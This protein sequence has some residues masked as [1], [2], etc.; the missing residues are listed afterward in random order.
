VKAHCVPCNSSGVIQGIG[1]RDVTCPNCRGIGSL[2][3]AIGQHAQWYA[4]VL[5]HFVNLD[6]VEIE[7]ETP[8][9][10]RIRGGQHVEALF[11]MFFM[12]ANA[13]RYCDL[14]PDDGPFVTAVQNKLA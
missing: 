7:G 5:E 11:S 2:E 12:L 14:Q 13:K 4:T 1:D 8:G 10:G 9:T 3:L 6:E